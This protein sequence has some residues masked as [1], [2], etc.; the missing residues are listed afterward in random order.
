MLPFPADYEFGEDL[1][2]GPGPGQNTGRKSIFV[3]FRCE[4]AF[5]SSNLRYFYVTRQ[6]KVT[7]LCHGHFGPRNFSVAGM[8]AWNNLPP[9]IKTSLTLG[10]F[11]GR[12]KMFLCAVAITCQRSRH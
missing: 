6:V 5:D 2:T 7:W 9:E 10:Q 12:L 4:N 3:N 11:S 1:P 8:L